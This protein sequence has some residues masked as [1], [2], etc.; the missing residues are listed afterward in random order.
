MKYLSRMS[1]RSTPF[2]LFAGIVTGVWG[3]STTL[4]LGPN[5]DDRKVVRLDWGIIQSVVC[6]LEQDPVVRSWISYRPNSSIYQSGDCY[7]YLERKNPTGKSG[8]FHLEAIKAT[9][10]LDLVLLKAKGGAKWEELVDALTSGAAVGAEEAKAFL[11]KIIDAQ[12]L[13][14]NLRPPLSSADPLGYLIKTLH[15]IPMGGVLA[16]PLEALARELR[17]FECEPMSSHSKWRERLQTVL[18]AI[19][20][21]ADSGN[22]IQVDL[23]KSSEGLTLSST[24][25]DEL[26]KGAETLRRLTPVT[27]L[28][29]MDRFRSAFSERYGDRWMPILEVLDEESGIGFDG[30]TPLGSSLLDGISFQRTSPSKIPSR[31]DLFLLSQSHCWQGRLIWELNEE[32]LE[33]LEN[34]NPH[35]FSHSF[36]ALVSLSASNQDAMDRGEFRF[37]MDQFSGATAARWLGRFAGGDPFLKNSLIEHLKLEEAANPEIIFA[38]V[39]HS[40]EGRMGNVLARPALRTYEIPY[41]AS[42]GVEE[43]QAIQPADLIVTVRGDRVFL[44]SRRLGK[45]VIPRLSSAHNFMRGPVV[46]R[47]LAH[48]QDQDGR[49]G[50]WSW[51]PLTDLPYLP[52]VTHGKHVISKARWRIEASELKESLAESN[53]QPWD[54]FQLLRERR[55]LPRLVMLVEGDNHLLVDMDQINRVETLHHI[56]KELSAFKLV[57]CFPD[58]NQLV[59]NSPE[60]KF[61]HELVIPFEALNHQPVRKAPLTQIKSGRSFRA[62]P[63]YSEWLYLKLYCGAFSADRLL[64]ELEPLLKSTKGDG[65]W[66][67]WHFVRY[68]DQAHHLRLRFHGRPERLLT[69]LLPLVQRHLAGVLGSETLWKI[70]VDTYDQ[71]LERYGGILGFDLATSWFHVDSQ[72]IL[73]HLMVGDDPCHRWKIGLAEVDAIWAA[74][75]LNILERMALA[76]SSRDAF[77]EEFQKPAYSLPEV[78]R[79]YREIRSEFQDF[80]PT[81]FSSNPP[82]R[83]FHLICIR[84]AAEEGALQEDLLSIAR[85]MAH[86]HLNRLLHAN[87]REQEWV[88]MELLERFYASALARGGKDSAQGLDTADSVGTGHKF[89]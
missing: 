88:L 5:S 24:I 52:R 18:T 36:S 23:Y 10:H 85:S 42:F 40:P 35:P 87:Q 17:R 31:R 76:R 15:E 50:G 30:A 44:A 37:F 47:F 66:D 61:A 19:G 69:E 21:P 56:V 67:K 12:V 32:D 29:P 48:L 8:A 65:I 83:Y 41:L 39:I 3:D 53:D 7:R 34:P 54:A 89:L 6:K 11:N 68:I 71:E 74:M 45:E 62:F 55:G 86:M 28:G 46:Y 1:S 14:S 57:E 63:P 2:G 77:R 59:V 60:G 84:D 22:F 38:E 81:P 70:Q 78:S 43:D 82:T 20:I 33:G 26:A 16:E 75:G 25:G 80:I 27:Q 72:N 13:C 9:S 58:P 51:G 73:D 49:P 64:R 4:T 79:K